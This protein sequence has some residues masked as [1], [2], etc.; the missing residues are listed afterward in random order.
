MDAFETCVENID[1]LAKM[2]N[3]SMQNV[4]D[5]ETVPNALLAIAGQLAYGNAV[6][7]AAFYMQYRPEEEE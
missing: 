6:A 4:A 1:L 5:E 3:R 2:A 7:A